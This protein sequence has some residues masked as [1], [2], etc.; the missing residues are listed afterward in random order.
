MI[1]TPNQKKLEPLYR[2]FETYGTERLNG[3]DE[4]YFLGLSASEKE[5]AWN[6]LMKRG[7]SE[8][9]V[10]GLYLLDKDRA[11]EVIARSLASPM[12]TS[13]YPAEQEELERTRLSMIGYVNSVNRDER[14]IAAMCDFARS[15]FESVRALFVQSLPVNKITPDAVEA[16]KG[17]I[18]TEVGTIPLSSAITKLMAIHGLEFDRH[19]PLYKSIYM[20]LRSDERKEK[21]SAMRRLESMRQPDY[22]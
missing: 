1:S 13:P 6:F 10:K 2:F 15:K 19:D 3:L 20:S 9:T 5:E 4:S 11:I 22:L 7:L 12:E 14:Y 17:M 16:L 21:L 18:F 8:E